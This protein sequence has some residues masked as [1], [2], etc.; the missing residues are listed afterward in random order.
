MMKIGL[1]Q[2]LALTYAHIKPLQRRELLELTAAVDRIAGEDVQA[3]VDS[4]S[5]DASL[6]DGYA[7]VSVDI[8][9]ATKEHPVCLVRL[10][11]TAAAG[12]MENITIHS[13]ITVRIL[14]GARIP[15]GADAVV[16]EEFVQVDGQ[17]I[18]V[19]ADAEA[20][21]NILRRG[22]DVASGMIVVR[23]G[24]R[25]TP[26]HIGLLAASGHS[27]VS[28][29]ARPTIGIIATGDEVVAPGEP[30]GEGKLYAS[31]VTT[32]ASWCQKFGMAARVSVCR[33]DF[34]V[35]SE[36]VRRMSS[37]TDALITSGGAW[38]G[39][40]DLVLKILD[41]LQWH[42]V[43]HRIRIGPGKAVGFGLLAGKPVF[44]LPG[45]PPSNLMGF[46]QIALPGVLQL[47]G[48]QQTSL[49]TIKVQLADDLYGKD[50]DWTQ[51]V[52][53]MLDY[54]SE[55]P[56]FQ[57]LP[58]KSRLAMMAEAQAVVAISEGMTRRHAGEIVEAQ[59]L[60]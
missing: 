58:G 2:A 37:Q 54:Q 30:L 48:H 8:A 33:D 47:G 25:L 18:L 10:E 50:A 42:K 24:T 39:D 22:S 26:G 4:P 13:G 16:A 46:L 19:T 31:N 28:V 17:R 52:F 40:R 45:G 36:V 43:F 35:I 41:K 32:L 21:R 7:V 49:P 59:L 11:S 56:I 60:T 23:K 12:G 15:R 20:G 27:Q 51:F 34:A 53:G 1:D 29:I 9:H 5:V 6:K 38:T 3:L 57:Q 44:V 14:T 55:T